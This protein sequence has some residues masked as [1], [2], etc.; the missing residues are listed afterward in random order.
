MYQITAQ[1]TPNAGEAQLPLVFFHCHLQ[2]FFI[3]ICRAPA[4]ELEIKYVAA[5]R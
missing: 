2:C 1:R 5:V 4:L 3:S